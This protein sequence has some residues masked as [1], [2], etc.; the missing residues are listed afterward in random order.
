MGR[1][2]RGAQ[3]RPLRTSAVVGL[4]LAA[5]LALAGV[6]FAAVQEGALEAGAR[7]VFP[8]GAATGSPSA[9]AASASASAEAGRTPSPDRLLVGPNSVQIDMTGWYAW[10]LMDERTGKIYGSR[11]MASTSTTASLIKAWIGA[12]FLRRSA[13]RGVTPTETRMTQLRKMIR[14]SDNE[15]AQSLWTA[16]GEQASIGRLISICRL[17][18]SA[19]S[20]AGWSRTRL[21]PRD[22][23]RL[24]AC[25]DD[26]RAA[27]PRW[28]RWLLGEMRAVRGDGDAGIRKAFPAS[29][30]KTIA[31]K[32]GWIDRSAEREYHI[33]CLA[34]GDDWTMGVMVRYPFGGGR[35]YDYGFDVCESVARQLRTDT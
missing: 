8:D 21:S 35:G 26:G 9:P 2:K 19:A 12:D 11:N 34:I 17:T 28:T 18:D 33:N 22:I 32:N 30:Q 7:L 24:G 6:G 16:V 23:T 31:I 25:I 29:I 5:V 13:E 3:S 14:D 10:A 1:R 4:A 15:A 27:G 20:G